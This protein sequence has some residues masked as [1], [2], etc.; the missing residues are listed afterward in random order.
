MS[1]NIVLSCRAKRSWSFIAI[2]TNNLVFK[3]PTLISIASKG[4]STKD[5]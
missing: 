4:A 5:F 3:Y 2:K 1:K